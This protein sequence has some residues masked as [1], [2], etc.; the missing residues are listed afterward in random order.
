MKL[1]PKLPGNYWDGYHAGMLRIHR[2]PEPS[3]WYG[4]RSLA[5]LGCTGNGR[6]TDH[7]T[8]LWSCEH[9]SGRGVVDPELPRC[10]AQEAK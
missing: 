9:W 3:S 1:H 2:R 8:R 7:A 6:N 10:T 4:Q 5:W